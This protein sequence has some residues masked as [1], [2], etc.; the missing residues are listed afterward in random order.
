MV[1]PVIPNKINI[2]IPK[3]GVN[4]PMVMLNTITTPK[5]MGSIPSFS[6]NGSNIGGRIINMGVISTKQPMMSRN[7]LMMSRIILGFWD[8]SGRVLP[9]R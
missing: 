1:L 9:T 8:R 7:T 4:N 6:N 3:G 2:P 5:C